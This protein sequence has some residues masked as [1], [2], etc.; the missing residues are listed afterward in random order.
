[1]SQQ[2]GETLASA[3]FGSEDDTLRDNELDGKHPPPLSGDPCAC[4]MTLTGNS[5]CLILL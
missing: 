1:M 5:T 3:F 4:L 2:P